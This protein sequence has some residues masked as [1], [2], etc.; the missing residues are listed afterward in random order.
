MAEKT[1]I[2]IPDDI[3]NEVRAMSNQLKDM[4]RDALWIC[5][6]AKLQ[7]A[8]MWDLIGDKLKE[9][10]GVPCSL[11]LDAGIVVVG[12]GDE[13]ADILRRLLEGME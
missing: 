9:T 1:K 7:N 12:G 2:Q 11:D 6:K 10:R 3:I 13:V 5:E 8:K 4:R